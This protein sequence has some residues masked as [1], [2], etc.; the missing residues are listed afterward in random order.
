MTME[1]VT[2]VRRGPMV[3]DANPS[4][5]RATVARGLFERTVRRLPLRVERRDVGVISPGPPGAPVMVIERDA[6]WRR[7]GR[8]GK[9]GFGEAYMAG[10]WTASDIAAVLKVFAESLTTLIPQPLQRL[11]RLYE[12]SLGMHGKNTVDRA[13]ENIVHH[14][15]LSNELFALFLDETMTYSCAVFEAGDS[16]AQAQERKYER[17]CAMLDL[18]A[19]DHLLEIG[20]GWGG[21]AM[22]AARSRGCQVTSV[23]ISPSQRA[24]ALERIATAGLADR[25]TV[26]ERDYRAIEG[27][28]SKIVSVEMFEAVGERYWPTFFTACDRLLAPGGAMAMQTITMP[29]SRFLTTRRQ[30]GWIHKYIFPGGLIPSMEAIDDALASGSALRVSRYDEIGGHYTR[31][32]AEWRERF[33]ANFDQVSALGFTHEFRRMWEFYLAYCEAGFATGALGDS[34]I[35]LS[36]NSR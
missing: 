8:D 13:V 28:Y 31:T 16:L 27:R 4:R 5:L 20:T 9:I 22:H 18:T 36:R 17:L 25:V 30:F 33:V 7:L 1:S 3:P 6:F 35:L 15:D 24:L 19:E 11:R 12:P 29:H 21:M 14:Y 2:D 10:D 34:Q 32:L 26:L 23:T